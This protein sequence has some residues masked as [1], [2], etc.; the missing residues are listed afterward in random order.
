MVCVDAMSSVDRVS[1]LVFRM[2]IP[3]PAG[4]MPMGLLITSSENEDVLTEVL[5]MWRD[6]C[7]P[8]YPFNKKGGD[9]IGPTLFMT[10]DASAEINSL[11][12]ILH[13]LL[14]LIPVSKYL[15]KKNIRSEIEVFNFDIF[16]FE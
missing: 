13:L 6:K 3:T 15:C 7:L 5:T 10:D 2:I 11:R 12:L 16:E 8:T 14:I 1:N 9:K 4:G